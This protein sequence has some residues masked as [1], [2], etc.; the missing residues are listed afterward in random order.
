MDTTGTTVKESYKV[1]TNRCHTCRDAEKN[2]KLHG[3]TKRK[4]KKGNK[5]HGGV[6]AGGGSGA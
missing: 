3:S 6:G 5:G 2:N 4:V 1:Y